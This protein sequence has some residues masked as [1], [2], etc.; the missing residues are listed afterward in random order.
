MSLSLPVSDCLL[1]TADGLRFTAL[2]AS[3]S[4]STDGGMSAHH[5]HRFAAYSVLDIPD[6]LIVDD[7]VQKCCSCGHCFSV[8]IIS[9][10]LIYCYCEHHRI[11][12]TVVLIRSV[13]T[14]YLINCS[15]Q[16]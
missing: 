1:A 5:S 9:C 13:T 12:A 11:V 6:L 4:A 2:Q 14:L 10:L 7:H 16:Q 15:W 3:L 8:M